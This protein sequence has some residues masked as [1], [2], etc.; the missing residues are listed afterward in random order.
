MAQTVMGKRVQ[1]GSN[2]DY[3]PSGAV[4]AGTVVEL[5]AGLVGVVEADIAA[6]VLGSINVDGV[7]DLPKATGAGK[8]ILV[9]EKVHWEDGAGVAT[10]VASGATY[11]GYA[12]KTAATT[13]TF[14]RT[15]LVGL[16]V[17][18]S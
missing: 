3:T 12:V 11:V 18:G 17:A 1:P 5:S 4:T 9:G 14:V 6:G 10:Q 2:I 7:W 13:D 16:G 8:D 15:K